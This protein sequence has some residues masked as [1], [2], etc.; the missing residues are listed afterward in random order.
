VFRLSRLTRTTDN[1][2]H[3]TNDP[4][5]GAALLLISSDSD[6]FARISDAVSGWKWTIQLTL[7]PLSASVLDSID[8]GRFPLIVYDG[9]GSGGDRWKEDF[10]TLRA[11]P[12]SP[13]ILLASRVFDHYLWEEVIRC[14]GFDV[15]AKSAAREQ[16][17]RTLRFAW[18]WK[19]SL[20]KRSQSL[21]R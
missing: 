10:L 7:P 9:D 21:N 8:S 17:I 14:G 16:L 4:E 12:G 11:T 13:C 5:P 3:T 15:I 20:W 6:L 2:A 19:K 1:G 18:F